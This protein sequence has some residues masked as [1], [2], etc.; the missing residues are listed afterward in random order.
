MYIELIRN[1]IFYLISRRLNKFLLMILCWSC[2][3]VFC[4]MKHTQHYD[5]VA[6]SNLVL[7]FN[8]L[9]VYMKRTPVATF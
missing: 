3:S 2:F 1:L 9:C 6:K 4:N 7:Y 5:V 8:Y